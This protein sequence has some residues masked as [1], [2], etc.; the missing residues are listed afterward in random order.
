ME[1][2]IVNWFNDFLGIGQASTTDGK[3]ALLHY[4][5]FAPTTSFLRV[6]E[7]DAVYASVESYKGGFMAKLICKERPSEAAQTNLTGI[8]RNL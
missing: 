4:K 3:S 8:T 5:N 6:S 7:G 2:L 1:K